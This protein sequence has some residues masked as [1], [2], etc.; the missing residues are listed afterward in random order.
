MQTKN[1]T[2]LWLTI[3]GIA[4]GFLETAVVIYLRR[5]YYP[6]GFKFPL[7]EIENGIL[8]VEILREVATI[9]MLFAIGFLAGKTKLQRFAFFIYSFAIWDIF[10][11]VF[12]KMFLDWPESLLTPDI[13]FLI[14]VPWIGPVIA[15][16]I[17]SLSMIILSWSIIRYD[18]CNKPGTLKGK[19]WKILIAGSLIVIISF[20][21]N[22]VKSVEEMIMSSVF[23]D[24]I[25]LEIIDSNFGP[26]NWILFSFGELIIVFE[27]FKILRM[28]RMISVIP[29]L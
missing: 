15:P 1:S 11:Y 2:I 8:S 28:K 26:L 12:L 29:K 25:A 10:Y 24:S 17:L 13:L 20:M 23:I 27:I 3:F 22:F 6:D 9:I 16:I 5:I 14:P 19:D 21:L 4:M 7:V 18:E